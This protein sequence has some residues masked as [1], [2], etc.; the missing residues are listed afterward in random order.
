MY[1]KKCKDVT[2]YHSVPQESFSSSAP[3]HNKRHFHLM[4]MN[5]MLQSYSWKLSDFEDMRCCSQQPGQNVEWLKAKWA[6]LSQ[7]HPPVLGR[8]Q[9]WWDLCGCSKPWLTG[10]CCV[11]RGWGSGTLSVPVFSPLCA[12]RSQ[13]AAHGLESLSRST[14]L[15]S[16]NPIYSSFSANNV[17]N[18]SFL[19]SLPSLLL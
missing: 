8:S 19:F 11:L 16:A 14:K 10:P 2:G 7:I 5:T 12:L 6:G 9:S 1:L 17:S 18:A 4:I 15:G 13:W 3:K